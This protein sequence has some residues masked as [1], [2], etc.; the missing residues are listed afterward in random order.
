MTI[1][2]TTILRTFFILTFS[3]C[4][5]QNVKNKKGKIPSYICL[6]TSQTESL[7]NSK[8]FELKIPDTWCSYKGF[9][10]IL[11]Y[12]PKSLFNLKDNHYKNC[13]YVAH[14]DNDTYKSKDIEEALGK[15]YPLLN[16][17]LE[18]APA[19]NSE[20]HRTYGKFYILKHKS[21]WEGETLTNLDVLFNYRNKDYILNYTVLEKDYEKYIN[22]VIQIIESFKILE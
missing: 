10:N 11:T 20:V 18:F 7:M 15:H 21:F 14:Y 17:T 6:N 1:R 2:N 12:S 3:Y 8:G 22:D 4:L 16:S 13:L 5:G 9:H 19:Y